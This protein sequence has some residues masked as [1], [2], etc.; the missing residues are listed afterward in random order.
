MTHGGGRWLALRFISLL[1]SG[2]WYPLRRLSQAT[3]LA[4]LLG[5]FDFAHRWPVEF[6]A[7]GVVDDAIQ[8]GV[9]ERG[10]AIDGGGRIRLRQL[11][12]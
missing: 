8:D 11:A 1:P 4:R 2:A 10:L 6:E 9:A 5:G 7:V 12:G 3:V